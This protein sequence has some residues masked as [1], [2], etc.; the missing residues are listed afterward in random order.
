MQVD[1]GAWMEHERT[2]NIS[3]GQTR[4]LIAALF[5]N[6]KHYAVNFTGPQTNFTALLLAP[7]GELTVGQWMMIVTINAENYKET[8][9]FL[10]TIENNSAIKCQPLTHLLW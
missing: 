10:L 3:R 2:V 7:V 6:G 9:R 4:H 1:Y 8:F 5:D